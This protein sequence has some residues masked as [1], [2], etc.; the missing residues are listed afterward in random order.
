MG[1]AEKARGDQVNSTEIRRQRWAAVAGPL[2]EY[3]RR[4]LGENE[5]RGGRG[6]E[7]LWQMHWGGA[8][9]L[10]L[11]SSNLRCCALPR[12]AT[13][14]YCSLGTA[15]L[16]RTHSTRPS[17]MPVAL[18]PPRPSALMEV[19]ACF[20]DGGGCRCRCTWLL[21]HKSHHCASSICLPALA[22]A[23]KAPECP[24]SPSPRTHIHDSRTRAE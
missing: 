13:T 17:S 8:I 12:S 19:A 24:V 5:H 1:V 14:T 23:C 7:A 4:E 15:C 2:V 16:S 21:L 18:P 6:G 22:I 11:V 20:C 10:L 3:R 9:I